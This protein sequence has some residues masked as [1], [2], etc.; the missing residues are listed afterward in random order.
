MKHTLPIIL[1]A[2]LI[3]G[4]SSTP[5]L[6]DFTN[7]P[8]GMWDEGRRLSEKG[9]K[10]IMKGEETIEDSRIDANKGEA[11]IQSGSDAIT[12]A[13][14]EYT[15]EVS[16]IGGSANPKEVQFEA[17]RLNAVG[18][19]WEKA[20]SNVEKGNDLLNKSR[21]KQAEGQEQIAEG[22]KL[23]ERGS[24]FIRNSQRMRLDQ[25]LLTLPSE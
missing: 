21:K 3:A 11:L 9:E 5:K 16:K 24:N 12:R 8:N 19:K 1:L 13:R 2:F 7:N 10:L 25:P 23:V 18:E 14:Q 22:R 4:C 15:V 20:I 17:A 6:E